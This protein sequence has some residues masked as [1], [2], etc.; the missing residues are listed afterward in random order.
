[1]SESSP[2]LK[3]VLAKLRALDR[4]LPRY[5]WPR[6]REEESERSDFERKIW[7]MG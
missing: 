6:K 2:S 5:A 3:M 4:V 7:G 1:M